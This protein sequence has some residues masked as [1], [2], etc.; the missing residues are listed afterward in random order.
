MSQILAMTRKEFLLWVRKPGSWIVVFIVPLLFIWI[1]QAVFGSSGTPVVSIYAVNE[2]ESPV[3][4]SVMQT[5]EDTPNLRIEILETRSEADRR[6]GAGDRMAAVVIPEGFGNSIS[7]P[8]GG[9][10]D[11][12][13]DPARSE[14]ANIVIG[15]V[16]AAL[17][18]FIVDAEVTR[19]V[20][21]SVDQVLGGVIYLE[22][23]PPQP[24][25]EATMVSEPTPTLLATPTESFPGMGIETEI[26]LMP[27]EELA[28]EEQTLSDDPLRIFLIAAIRG[29]VSNQV[30]EAIE[31]PQIRLITQPV[32]GQEQVR[33]PSL[34]DHLVPGYSL[35]FM[36]FLISSL[37]VTVVEE[38]Q[39]GTLRRLLTAPV[40]RS[41]ILLGKMLPYF[42]IAVIQ[43]VATLLLSQLIFG[44]DLGRGLDGTPIAIA[45]IILCSA[46]AMSGLGVLIAALARTES[47]ADG[48]A[49]VIVLVL[50]V[51][52]GSMFPNIFIPG[53]QMVTPHYW[54]MEGFLNVIARG[55]G[56][57]GVILPAGVLLTMAAFF[58]TAGAIKFRFE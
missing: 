53:L 47:Q 17:G 39:T 41:R 49:I 35:M 55:Q 6:V 4:Q 16:N 27:T 3:S 14:Q 2:D 30:Q 33:H 46:L 18:P 15:L 26:P 22:D 32:Q 10:I 45:V 25:L 8:S 36:Y 31:N 12:L 5:L 58:F 40:S 37:A 19:S 13:I 52:S 34:L 44:I 43:M 23:S 29:V 11:I 50:A 54:S 42:L 57:E 28:G 20:E 21:A 51:V 24:E 7:S 56:L 48:L 1:V 38:R 9:K